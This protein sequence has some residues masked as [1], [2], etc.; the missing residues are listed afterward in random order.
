MKNY[1][2][3]PYIIKGLISL[4][5]AVAGGIY[6]SNVPKPIQKNILK[7]MNTKNYTL[8]DA[9]NDKKVDLIKINGIPKYLNE[10]MQNILEN[11]G[12]EYKFLGFSRM[13]PISPE[14]Q[15][16]AD[17]VFNGNSSEPSLE[18]VLKLK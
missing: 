1:K 11:S 7:E 3:T 14:I 9:N 10:N 5:I 15:Y 17:L 12:D 4:G 13:K 2:A 18:K 8:V 6:I 16:S